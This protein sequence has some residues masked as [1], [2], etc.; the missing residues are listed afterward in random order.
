VRRELRGGRGGKEER[1]EKK[2]RKGKKEEKDYMVDTNL[3]VIIL[4]RTLGSVVGS[5]ALISTGQSKQCRAAPIDPS[6]LLR[7]C[8]SYLLQQYCRSSVGYWIFNVIGRRYICMVYSKAVKI[9]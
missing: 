8:T 6:R 3:P 1:E 2:S 4:M 9:V 5:S 7:T